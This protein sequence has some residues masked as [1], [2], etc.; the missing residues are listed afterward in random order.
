MKRLLP[1][2]TLLLL[3]LWGFAQDGANDPTF[4]TLDNGRFGSGTGFNGNVYAS[5]L[6]PDGKVIVAGYFTSYNGTAANR[7]ARLNT[8][9]SLDTAFDPGAGF[10]NDVQ[11]LILQPDGKI[12]AGGSFTAF[13]GAVRKFIARLNADG[14]VD[15]SF[16]PGGGFNSIVQCIVVQPD[17]RILA[18]GN[19]T[20]YNDVPTNRIARLNAD[21][22]LDLTFD[23]STGFNNIVYSM[24]LQPDGRIL[25]GGNFTL[26]NGVPTNRIARINTDGSLDATF[27]TGTGFDGSPRAIVLQ[28]NGK[29]IV[30]GSFDMFNGVPRKSIAR[31]NADGSPDLTFDSSTGFNNI[32]YSMAL[33]PDGRIMVNGAFTT[34]KGIARNR[35]VRLGTDGSLD[36]TFDTGTGFNGSAWTVTLQPDGKMLVGGQF[37]Y[38]KGSAKNRIIRLNTDGTE[39][40]GFNPFAGFDGIVFSMAPQP[41][42]KI[43]VGGGFT[44]YNGTTVNRIVRLNADGTMD[45]TFSPGTGFN[46]NG[47]VNTIALQY[48][49]KILAGGGFTS[50]NGTA[51]NRIVRLNPDG[52]LDMGFNP[53]TGFDNTVN[54]IALQPDGKIIAGGG[55]T[56]YNGTA[57][58]RIVRLNADG[59]MDTGFNTGTG[60]DNTVNS[61]VLQ[62]DG[63]VIV[64]GYFTSY[65]GTATNRIARLNTDGSLDT[66]FDPGAGFNDDVQ[67]L[68]LQPDGK[69]LAGGSFTAF[70]GT[71]RKFIARLNGD[72]SLDVAFDPGN[73]FNNTVC[74]INQQPDGKM[75]VGGFF[76]TFKSTPR[77]SIAR[78]NTDGTLDTSFDP[79]TGFNNQVQSIALQP[80]GKII[81]GGGF[82]LYNG[83]PRNRIARLL[84]S[85]APL[86]VTLTGFTAKADG[87]LAKLQWQTAAEH[88]NKG[89]EVYRGTDDGKFVLLQ[90][91]GTKGGGSYSYTDSRPLRG[92]NYYKLVQVDY[93]GA[94]T[95]LGI[96]KVTFDFS[97]SAFNLY[98][99]PTA[100]K[101]TVG[102]S[103]NYHALSVSDISGKVLQAHRLDATQ[104]EV[105]L[106]L[107]KYP[108]GIYFINLTGNNGTETRKVIRK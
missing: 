35:I 30:G 69:I 5:V 96:R 87:Y 22:S 13:G 46:T 52:T 65:N 11:T 75:V 80:D 33:Q 67:T 18:G 25:A 47:T 32:V 20:L 59:S 100:D 82:T 44:I 92:N 28:S 61:I 79:G 103:G 51:S 40:T 29:L 2:L 84:S 70:G 3:C 97:R 17:G 102:L 72:A 24:S 91:M 38:F 63:K 108:S 49:A 16:D 60:F 104:G 1:L 31:L 107:S 93:D 23:S 4:N 57:V 78:L 71:V 7:I 8:D 64:A 66:A 94:A 89:F 85:S 6:Q 53:G 48:D 54:S 90:E 43:V 88:N 42:G 58:K 50:Y 101:V 41:D 68:I 56:T 27:S 12:L 15:T 95:E 21:G 62:P 86:P 105:V 74:S 106:N 10:N 34:F 45:V 98:P 76:T 9:G 36:A 99:N 26:Y 83:S 73:G 14:S 77:N 81:A 37:T 19:F 55:F 39:D